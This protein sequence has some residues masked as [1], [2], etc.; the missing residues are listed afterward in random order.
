M[1]LETVFLKPFWTC[2]LTSKGAAYYLWDQ[3]QSLYIHFN[4]APF[5][6]Y[7]NNLI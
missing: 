1:D 4:A 2:I 7:H 3:W 6:A 5:H